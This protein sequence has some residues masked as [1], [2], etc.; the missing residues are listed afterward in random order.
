MRL[1]N[2]LNLNWS[3]LKPNANNIRVL[4]NRPTSM[5]EQQ[6]SFTTLGLQNIYK[7]YKRQV[8]SD[9]NQL[10]RTHMLVI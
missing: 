8:S 3:F 9:V 7:Y 2:L 10:P 6:K 4:H 5:N 1:P